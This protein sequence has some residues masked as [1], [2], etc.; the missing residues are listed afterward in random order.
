MIPIRFR[1]N[2]TK[3]V[4]SLYH[5]LLN[6]KYRQKKRKAYIFMI[7]NI[8]TWC[9]N[10]IIFSGHAY[11]FPEIIQADY[12]TIEK[13][14]QIIDAGKS[15]PLL[16][17]KYIIEFL[18][19]HRFPRREFLSELE[20]TVC[21]YCNRN[22][23]NSARKRTMCDLDHFFDKDTYPI[24]AVSFYNIVPVCHS[25]NH[26]KAS[27]RI[28][29][30]SHNQKYKTDDLVTFDYYIKGM[31]F[32]VDKKQL[33]IEIETAMELED[34]VD[35]LKLREVYQ[36]H[37]DVVQ[38]CI[39]KAIIFEP[40]YLNFLYYTY[41]ELFESEEELYRIVYGDY[42]MEEAYGKRPLAKL[43]SDIISDLLEI[44]E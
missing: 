31:D 20:V 21:P 40:E 10:N 36:I 44:Y 43:T 11:T 29:Y 28:S 38:E 5:T 34:N 7:K 15:L 2:E 25:C 24:L 8:N 30:S 26:I 17:K 18:Y 6:I 23:V 1:N 19:A 35:I 39:K 41:E 33:G 42:I 37:T 16:Y 22:F 12:E 9:V 14:A 4:N 32:L 3:T 13:I 27:Q